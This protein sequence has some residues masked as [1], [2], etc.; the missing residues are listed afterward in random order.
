MFD[1]SS[2]FQQVLAGF[3]DLIVNQIL[4][5]ISGLFGGALG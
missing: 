2:I 5:M 1:F 4:T 3:S